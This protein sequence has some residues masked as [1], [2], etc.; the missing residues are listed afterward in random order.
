MFRHVAELQPLIH[1]LSYPVR[2]H[3]RIHTN[4]PLDRTMHLAE[5]L[6][7]QDEHLKHIHGR[8]L[9]YRQRAQ[10]CLDGWF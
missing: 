1:G 10:R 5:R 2:K 9:V 7:T 8:A 3:T 6:E 4:N